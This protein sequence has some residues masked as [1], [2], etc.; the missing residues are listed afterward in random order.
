LSWPVVHA[1]FVDHATTVLPT[2]RKPV[3]ALGIDETR[4]GKPRF[5]VNTET[6]V[7]EQVTD[8]WHTGFVDLTGNQGLLGQTEGPLQQ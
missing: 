4:R 5:A 3:V 1:A 6:E 8:R 7:L 2:S